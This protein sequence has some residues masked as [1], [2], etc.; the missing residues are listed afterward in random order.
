MRNIIPL[1]ELPLSNDFMFGIVMTRPKICKLFLEALLGKPI[2]NIEYID[3][4][5][6]AS[7]SYNFHGIRLDVYL[8][9]DEGVI[10]NV[11]MQAV[12]HNNLER[13]SRFY[14]SGID[15]MALEKNADFTKLKDSFVIFVCNFDYYGRGLA[16]YEREPQ[17]KG[18]PGIVYDDGAR[19]FFLNSK[20]ITENAEKSILEFLDIVRENDV[21]AS[22][23]S[24][25]AQETVTAVKETRQDKSKEGIYMTYAMQRMDDLREGREEGREEGE[26]KLSV[27]IQKLLQLHRMDDIDAATSNAEK[28]NELYREFNID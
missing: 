1:R 25:L 21:T 5:K 4:Q 15:R 8:A 13:R 24:D 3:R 16:I 9:D 28:R 12:N 22:Y 19:V 14:Q 17:V 7:D 27:L 18:C 2:A 26:M 23:T 11:E 10:Y 6:D 20:Y